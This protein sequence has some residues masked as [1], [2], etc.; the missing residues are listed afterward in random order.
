VRTSRHAGKNAIRVLVADSTL[1]AC[2]LVSQG[3]S[4]HSQFKVVGRATTVQELLDLLACAGPHVALVSATLQDRS[5]N[6][7][8]A[9]P[10]V[11]LQYPG[12]RLVLMVDHADPELVVA[13]FR[14]GARGIFSRSESH[15]D[16]LCKCVRCVHLGQI[17][18]NSRQLEYLLDAVAQTPA[19]RLVSADGRNLLSKR[20]EEVVHLVAEGLVNHEIAEQLHLSDHTVKNHLFHIFD[21]LGISSRVELVLYAVS[22][23][24]RPP[25]PVP[26]EESSA[27]QPGEQRS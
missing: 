25:A 26:A 10:Q 24:K 23:S 17:W 8:A 6:G 3:L 14:A 5:L 20:E 13:A 16:A 22:S 18:A 12:V 7:L 19:L 9:L 27:S 2:G 4:Q 21:K 11:R 1:M 15:F